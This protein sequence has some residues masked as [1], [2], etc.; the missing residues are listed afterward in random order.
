MQWKSKEEVRHNCSGKVECT[1]KRGELR[2]KPFL[3]VVHAR[4]TE[5]GHCT[6]NDVNLLETRTRRYHATEMTATTSSNFEF[7]ETPEIINNRM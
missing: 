3:V 5:T 7:L 1:R 4:A 6:K 2:Q